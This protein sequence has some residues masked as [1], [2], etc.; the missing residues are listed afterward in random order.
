M[1]HEIAA[2]A[3]ENKA[4]EEEK[5]AEAVLDGAKEEDDCVALEMAAKEAKG[6][7]IEADLA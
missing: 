2:A 4:G 5:K 3:H 7:K 6:H 1:A